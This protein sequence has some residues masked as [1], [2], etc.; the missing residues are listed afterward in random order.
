MDYGLI[1][2]RLPHSFSREIHDKIADYDYQLCEISRDKLEDFMTAHKF[3]AINVTI[4]YKEAVIPYLS[5]LD[6]TAKLCGAVNTVVN[7]DGRLVG[8]NTD[9]CGMGAL[10][11]RL[12]IEL[13]GK[14]VL[15]LGTGGT[16]KTAAALAS[17]SG[18][19]NVVR[20]SRTGRDGS[21]TYDE[22]Y[23]RMEDSDI[24]INTTPCGMYPDVD[25]VP[26]LQD[27]FKS[28]TG[29]VDAV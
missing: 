25:G 29:V 11:R 9:I 15:I 14:T 5:E 2:E 19:L 13:K 27:R 17:M 12:G 6:E 10:V 24:I 23:S 18:A 20:V 3:K 4:P 1:G 26:I 22:A 21:V 28:L 8:Y 7:R 16:S